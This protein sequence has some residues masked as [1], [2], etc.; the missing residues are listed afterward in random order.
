M[1]LQ[2]NPKPNYIPDP[3]VLKHYS[4]DELIYLL[5][6]TGWFIGAKGQFGNYSNGQNERLFIQGHKI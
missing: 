4:L 5:Q 6:S 2:A 3:T 1:F